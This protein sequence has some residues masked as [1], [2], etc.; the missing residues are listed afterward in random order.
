MQDRPSDRLAVPSRPGCDQSNRRRLF[1][2]D[3][4]HQSR[5]SAFGRRACP[6]GRRL[7]DADT[8]WYFAS[9]AAGL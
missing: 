8:A 2:L 9:I 3:A 6:S 1:Q 4:I 5:P 7:I